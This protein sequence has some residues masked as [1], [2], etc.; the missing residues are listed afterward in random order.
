LEIPKWAK[1]KGIHAVA[2][3]Q[4]APYILNSHGLNFVTGTEFKQF[5]LRFVAA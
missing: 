5:T 3:V 4:Q 2:L 1:V